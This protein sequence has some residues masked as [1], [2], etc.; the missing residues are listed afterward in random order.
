MFTPSQYEIREG[1]VLGNVHLEGTTGPHGCMMN[2]KRGSLFS[3][4]H[5]QLPLVIS[6]QLSAVRCFPFWLK[7]AF[8]TDP[9]WLEIFNT[10]ELTLLI[11]AAQRIIYFLAFCSVV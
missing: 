11:T 7:Q 6:C 2:E 1:G 5:Q 10:A 8:F 4:F 3:A 9:T